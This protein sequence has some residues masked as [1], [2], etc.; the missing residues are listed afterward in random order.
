M[1]F[2][3]EMKYVGR[4]DERIFACKKLPVKI[5]R[6]TKLQSCNTDRSD[7]LVRKTSALCCDICK[8]I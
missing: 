3:S 2:F 8:V 1:D 4:R 5:I 7:L 6:K